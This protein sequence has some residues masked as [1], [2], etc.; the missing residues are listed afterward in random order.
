MGFSYVAVNSLVRDDLHEVP[1][2][3]LL[4]VIQ[5]AVALLKRTLESV[6]SWVCHVPISS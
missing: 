2:V 6:L 3:L 1:V 5:S 4:G